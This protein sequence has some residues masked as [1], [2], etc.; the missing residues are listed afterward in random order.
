MAVQSDFGVNFKYQPPELY[1]EEGT[2]NYSSDLFVVGCIL[3][4]LITGEYPFAS[5]Q[6]LTSGEIPSR[7]S[8]S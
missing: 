7:H 2:L 3:F 6:A 8:G 5:R 1:T 4:E